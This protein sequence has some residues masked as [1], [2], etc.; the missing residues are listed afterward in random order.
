MVTNMKRISQTLLAITAIALVAADPPKKP[1]PLPPDDPA[2]I[3]E[4]KGIGDVRIRFDR[5]KRNLFDVDLGATSDVQSAIPLLQR[6][7][8]VKGIG[9]WD[10]GTNDLLACVENWPM[11]EV[12]N[13]SGSVFVSD[14]GMRHL[15]G[16]NK[17]WFLGLFRTSVGDAGLKD[18][19]SLKGLVYLNLRQTPVT[20]VGLAHL[21]GLKALEH[22]DLRQT[23]I[24]DKGLEAIGKLQSLK[25]L[26]LDSTRISDAGL[27]SLAH[28]GKLEM[29]SLGNTDVTNAGVAKLKPLRGL[30]SL[31]LDGA[32]ATEEVKKEFDLTQGLNISG[33]RTQADLQNLDDPADVAALRAVEVRTLRGPGL[34]VY[35]NDLRNVTEIDASKWEGSL[36]GFLPRLKKLHSLA[37]LQLPGQTTNH[38][39]IRVSELNTLKKLQIYQAGISDGGTK[40]IGHLTELEELSLTYCSRVTDLTAERLLPL[41]KLKTLDMGSTGITDAGLKRIAALKAL[42]HLRLDDTKVSDDGLVAVAN[43]AELGQLGLNRTLVTDAGLLHLTGLKKLGCLDIQQTAVSDGAVDRIR[44]AIPRLRVWPDHPSWK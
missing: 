9:A 10:V 8:N 13:L 35:I 31:S 5:R 41:K 12:I 7:H 23:G 11:L 21:T 18:I 26:W 30:R 37:T 2:I 27:G 33:L 38:D 4:L 25:E 16:V 14:A 43:L 22:L 19:G 36:D 39:L 40:N 24:S 32:L 3:A 34:H 1:N 29:L 28:L 44:K 20:D 6:L 17:L 42:E 15:R